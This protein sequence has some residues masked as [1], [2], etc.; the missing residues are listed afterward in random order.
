MTATLYEMSFRVAQDERKWR[1]VLFPRVNKDL[2]TL[3]ALEF[4]D[5]FLKP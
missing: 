4:E 1:L 5:A 2:P 3:D